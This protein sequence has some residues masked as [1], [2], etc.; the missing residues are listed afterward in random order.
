VYTNIQR[1]NSDIQFLIQIKQLTVHI[2]LDIIHICLFQ[3]YAFTRYMISE[4]D[5][6][7][8]F[9]IFWKYYFIFLKY[10]AIVAI[11]FY[12][13]KY[14]LSKFLPE[15]YTHLRKK[16]FVCIF[17]CTIAMYVMIRA[18]KFKDDMKIACYRL[19][20]DR[21]DNYYDGVT[22]IDQEL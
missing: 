1:N 14:G 20:T 5:R 8:M 16:L 21:F 2:K 6:E 11:L 19:K 4:N 13:Y 17:S 15:Q 22:Q 9:L 18:K 7:P 10:Y 3:L 12:A